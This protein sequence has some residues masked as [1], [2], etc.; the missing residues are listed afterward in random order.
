MGQ[1]YTPAYYSSFQDSIA[2]LCKSILPFSLKKRGLPATASEA[3][4]KLS[5]QHS[6]YLK[7]QQDSFHRILNL[8]GLHK[9][10]ILP[11]SEVSL[12]KS[13]LLLRLTASP[14]PQ[15]EHPP[16][17]RDKLLFLQELLYAK[18][19][20][21][22]EY[23]A[24]KRTLLQ[25][26]ARDK[27]NSD[28]EWSVIDLRD[29]GQSL[30]NKDGDKDGWKNKPAS[31]SSTAIKQ[32]FKGA[33]TVLGFGSSIQKQGRTRNRAEKSIF[34]EPEN[35]ALE[36]DRAKKRGLLGFIGKGGGFDG[37]KKKKWGN[38]ETLNNNNNEG[39]NYQYHHGHDDRTCEGP[40]TRQIKKKLQS[41]VS[42]SDFFIDKV[43]GDN[44]K[45]ELTRIQAE[46]STK[47][48][49]LQFSNEEME[50]I[51]SKLPV[52]KA[53]LHKFFPKSWCDRH[54]E[55]VLDVVKKEFKGH[56]RDM[57]SADQRKNTRPTTFDDYYGG[58]GDD[59]ENSHPNLFPHPTTH[60]H[61]LL[62]SNSKH[63]ANNKLRNQQSFSNPFWNSTTATSCYLGS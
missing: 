26:Q 5:K 61:H 56:V 30:I 7:W 36:S 29:D 19:I 15:H 12:F 18:C 53:D 25:M 45:K 21:D 62:H 54:G 31:S 24:S 42:A 2:S 35:S 16:I 8:M 28:E 11:E 22:E 58:G 39:S 23:Q 43:R 57:D 37:L 14:Q 52:D 46:L 50:S 9:E 10:G 55:V 49:S 59:N 51:S 20:S 40:D 63:G 60:H 34:D 4:A 48:T 6:D 41:D 38:S 33:A 47:N 27:E 13:E 44:I 32:H 1:T 17:L 3:E